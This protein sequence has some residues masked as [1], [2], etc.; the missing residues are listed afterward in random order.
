M[1]SA[2]N[3]RRDILDPLYDACVWDADE[4]Q[5]RP[6]NVETPLQVSEEYWKQ[7]LKGDYPTECALESVSARFFEEEPDHNRRDKPRLD[8]V[9]SFADG[10]WVRY[11]PQATLIWSGETY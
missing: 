11:H 10:R 9:L 2:T 8:I 1:D 7:T 6:R 5:W 3:L 4:K